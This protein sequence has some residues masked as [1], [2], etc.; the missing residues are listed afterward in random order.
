MLEFQTSLLK[1]RLQQMKSK[2][3][4]G[5]SERTNRR[6]Q[7]SYVTENGKTL[8]PPNLTH[9]YDMNKYKEESLSLPLYSGCKSTVLQSV[10][11]HFS[12]FTANNGMSKAALSM[13]LENEKKALPQPNLLPGSYR[14]AHSVIKPFLI[15]QTVYQL[16]Q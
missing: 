3:L 1:E 6:N 7:A 9:F 11:R 4:Y 5:K 12:V 8:K 16:C 13:C 2:Q 10:L 15:E 14:D